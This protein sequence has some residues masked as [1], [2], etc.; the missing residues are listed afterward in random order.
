MEF[1]SEKEQKAMEHI[2]IRGP[3]FLN[4]GSPASCSNS[5]TS[6]LGGLSQKLKSENQ[7]FTIPPPEK[8]LIWFLL[9]VLRTVTTRT[10]MRCGD[11][12]LVSSAQSITVISSAL[13]PSVSAAA[14]VRS[15]LIDFPIL[16]GIAIGC[17]MGGGLSRTLGSVW[18]A[19]RL[20]K[21][22]SRVSKRLS[23]GNLL[24]ECC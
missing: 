1:S 19:V 22:R 4:C 15:G 12:L 16:Q 17:H 5:H 14:P 20:G 8:T 11:I 2:I 18:W 9:W 10:S 7:T 6:I 21:C 13:E 3:I 24:S 23:A